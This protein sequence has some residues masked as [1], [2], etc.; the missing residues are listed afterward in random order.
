MSQISEIYL[1]TCIQRL[2]GYKSLLCMVKSGTLFLDILAHHRPL[3]LLIVTQMT[4]ILKE[5][6]R[7]HHAHR[8]DHRHLRAA[9]DICRDVKVYKK[10]LSEVVPVLI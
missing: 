8:N 1:E 4:M 2:A 6:E 10:I 5:Y 9:I 3:P 7:P